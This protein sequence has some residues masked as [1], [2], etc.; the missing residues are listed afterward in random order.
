MDSGK[1][2]PFVSGRKKAAKPAN[3]PQNPK[4]MSENSAAMLEFVIKGA[5]IPPT[6]ENKEQTPNA[7]LLTDVGNI[8]LT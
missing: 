2:L 3:T 1:F 4:I 7:V 8:S 6:R 5:N